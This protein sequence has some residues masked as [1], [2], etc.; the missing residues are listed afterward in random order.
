MFESGLPTALLIVGFALFNF[1]FWSMYSALWRLGALGSSRGSFG[2]FLAVF[3]APKPGRQWQIFRL[4]PAV[5]VLGALCCFAGVGLS[6]ARR[7]APCIASCEA[8]E[9]KGGRIRA[10]PHD[11]KD[12]ERRC[13]CYDGSASRPVWVK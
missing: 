5:V 6:D 3:R 10:N 7:N 9:H 8:A 1:G 13:W 12:M 4:G 2:R 11:R